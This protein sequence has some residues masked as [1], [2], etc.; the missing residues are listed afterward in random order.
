MEVICLQS[1]SSGNCAYVECDDVR[2][3]IDAG[4]SARQVDVRLKSLGKDSGALSA[5]LISHDHSDHT[6]CLGTIHRR[7]DLPIHVS[8][9]TLRTVQRKRKQGE[10]RQIR[11]FESDESFRIG[12]VTVE[13]IRTPHDAA[14]PVAFVIDD[15]VKRLGVLTDLGHSF[16]RLTDVIGTLDAVVLESNYDPAMLI[17]SRYPDMLKSRIAGDRG[18]ISNPDAVELLQKASPDLQWAM[19]AHLS[20]E[21]NDPEVAL[22]THRKTLGPNLKLCCADRYRVSELLRIEA[23]KVSKTAPPRL[24]QQMLFV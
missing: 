14:D 19:L 22:R 1:G 18:H 23:P 17:E 15:G 20:E 13:T 12:H 2:L 10:L 16:R 8:R 11:Y 24:R 21:C 9:A 4:I 7:F 6:R 3:L 5:L